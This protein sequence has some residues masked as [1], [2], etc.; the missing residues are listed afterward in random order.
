VAAGLSALLPGLGQLTN[1]DTRLAAIFA[2][3]AVAAILIAWLLL[4]LDGAASLAARV[5][6]PPILGI[7]LALNA[8]FLIWRLAS[9]GHAFLNRRFAIAPSRRGWLGLAVVMGLVALPHGLVNVVGTA[10]ESTFDRVFDGGV[11]EATSP[12]GPGST[13]R[14]NVLVIGLDA[15]PT[16]TAALTDTLMVVSLDPVG[17]TVTMLSVP[18]DTV[19]VPL[20]NGDVFGPK[21][22][23]LYGYA[24]RHPKDFPD[25]GLTAVE[26]AVGALLGIEIH[27]RAVAD[28]AG[29]VRI[30]DAV[31]GVDV[32]VARGFDD[33]IYDR[34]GMPPGPP[35]GWSIEAGPQHLDGV[36]ALAYARSR[37]AVGE[38][39]FSRAGRQQEV[40]VALREASMR[41]ENLLLRLPRLLDAI[42]DSVRTN[43]PRERLPALAAMATEIDPDS[44]VRI[45]LRRP[46]VRGGNNRYGSVQVP[47]IEAIRAVAAAA[48]GPPGLPP[49]P[50]PTPEPTK[51]APTAP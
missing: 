25:G 36:T 3:P 17:R 45:V 8:L 28:L 38:S 51:A 44:I 29:F 41:G 50:W 30:V 18:R 9:V 26:R 27:Y 16:R 32:N 31:G 24:E 6:A 34:F 42:G 2:A 14:L 49:Q 7:L 37:Y 15:A 12:P 46:L 35:R 11:A 22:N 21:L 33:P 10:A 47:D 20:G 48:F 23:A 40:L 43:L 19:N 5:V 39:D 4:Q 1:R 13:E